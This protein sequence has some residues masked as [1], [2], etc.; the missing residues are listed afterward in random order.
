MSTANGQIPPPYRDDVWP[1]QGGMA[2]SRDQGRCSWLSALGVCGLPFDGS[3][4]RPSRPIAAQD[5]P[6]Y[7]PAAFRQ[8][9]RA[10]RRVGA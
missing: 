9:L 2:A 4:F 8:A 3:K 5:P 7:C 1:F 10:L 6:N